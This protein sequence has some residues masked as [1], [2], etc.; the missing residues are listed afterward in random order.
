VI[1]IKFIDALACPLFVCDVCR[2]A[3]TEPGM[4][5]W[6]EAAG[7]LDGG[8]CQPAHVHKKRCLDAFEAGLSAGETL[9]TDEL[10]DHVGF[11]L[12]NSRI[13]PA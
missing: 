13:D 10:V 8:S 12:A 7:A 5:V 3:I 4:A 6:S 11:L 9:M 1:M 2:E